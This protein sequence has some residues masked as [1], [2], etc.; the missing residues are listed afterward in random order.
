VLWANNLLLGYWALAIA[1]LLVRPQWLTAIGTGPAALL[2]CLVAL[3]T[4]VSLWRRGNRSAPLFSLAWIF[5][6]VGTAVHVAALQG[7]LP[8]NQLTLR[9]QTL[10]F[11]VE[12]IL[13]SVALADRINSERSAR[14]AAQTALIG[15]REARLASQEQ[16]LVEQ[17]RLNEELERRVLARTAELQQST[18]ELAEANAELTRLSNTDAL[19]QLANRRHCDQQLADQAN[20]RLAVLLID[21]DRFKRINDGYGHPFGDRCIAAV[22]KVL[23]GSARRAGDLAARYGGE[24]FLLVLADVDAEGARALAERIRAEVAAL[25]L[26]HQGARVPLSVSI[27]L[28]HHDGQAALHVQALIDAADQA[29]YAAKAAGRN[30]VCVA[31]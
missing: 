18:R 21:I 1:L 27:G 20:T 11:F 4:A 7:V 23:R 25:D 31:G 28:V 30:Q 8:V 26:Q 19:T 22:A 16:L 15:E 12:F 13:L 9:M 5:L 17:A 10:G 29:L 24:E 2:S 6:I 3:A 14:I